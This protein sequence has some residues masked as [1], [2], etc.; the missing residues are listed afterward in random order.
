MRK[1]IFYLQDDLKKFLLPNTSL[2][3]QV[4]Q[5]RGKQFRFQEGRLTQRILLGNKSYFIK[6]HSGIGWSEIFKNLLQLRL[7]IIGAQNEWLAIKKLN[8]LGIQTPSIVGF[9]KKGFNPSRQQSFVL[10][11]ELPKTISLEDLKPPLAFHLKLKLLHEIAKIARIMHKNGINHRDFY[12]CHFLLTQD[13]HN[14][15][16]QKNLSEMP[17]LFLI[18]LHR[19]QIRHRIPKRWIIKDLAGLYFSSLEKDLTQKDFLRFMRIYSNKSLRE[20]WLTEKKFWQ[21]VKK[22]GDRLYLKECQH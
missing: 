10:M 12:L 21:K 9:G 8:D 14:M 7:P 4:M 20:I 19:A 13:S 22:R 5:L 17:R 3:E 16:Q 1:P 15:M 11:N 2:F 6:Q 18:D